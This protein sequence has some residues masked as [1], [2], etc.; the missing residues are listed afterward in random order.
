M[1]QL[2]LY[3]WIEV[4]S[5]SLQIPSGHSVRR[6]HVYSKQEDRY[7]I[8]SDCSWVDGITKFGSTIYGGVD[9]NDVTHLACNLN[10]L[11]LV[12]YK[13]TK[14]NNNVTTQQS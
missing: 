1:H 8:I 11:N 4:K 12:K 13:D 3:S 10:Q 5:P 9:W 14:Y 6:M 7:Y 2:I